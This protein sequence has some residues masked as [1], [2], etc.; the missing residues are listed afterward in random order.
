M[1]A[2]F[3][4]FQTTRHKCTWISRT[5]QEKLAVVNVLSHEILK[6]YKPDD[7]KIINKLMQHERANHNDRL[8]FWKLDI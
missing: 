6:N 4:D 3:D 8:P 2:T 1:N 5:A 7:I